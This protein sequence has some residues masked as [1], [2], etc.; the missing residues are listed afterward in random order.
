[1]GR[2]R[3]IETGRLVGSLPPHQAEVHRR[4]LRS[5]DELI[6]EHVLSQIGVSTEM[7]GQIV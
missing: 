1:L 2:Q 6:E 5:I 4:N 7:R 3:M